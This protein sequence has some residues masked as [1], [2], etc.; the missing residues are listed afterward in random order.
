MTYARVTLTMTATLANA[1][2]RCTLMRSRNDESTV[3]RTLQ[4]KVYAVNCLKTA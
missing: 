3:I 1:I 4:R 2:T